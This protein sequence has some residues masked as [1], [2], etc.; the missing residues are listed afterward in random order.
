MAFSFAACILAA[1]LFA[2]ALAL[3]SFSANFAC[4]TFALAATRF[5][6]AFAL[7]CAARSLAVVT[8]ETLA[9]PGARTLTFFALIFF[10]PVDLFAGLRAAFVAIV[11][12]TPS[13]LYNGR[14]YKHKP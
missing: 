14:H 9:L 3:F 7:A 12:F 8:L 2:A 13:Q 10:A 6:A 11:I 1:A 5:A 4:C